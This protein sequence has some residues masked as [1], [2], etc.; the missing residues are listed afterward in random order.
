MVGEEAAEPTALRRILEALKRIETQLPSSMRN[1]THGASC[2]EWCK[3]W[4]FLTGAWYSFGWAAHGL[5]G[6]ALKQDL[7][8]AH[9][10]ADSFDISWPS[11]LRPTDINPWYTGYFLVAAEHRIANTMHRSCKLFLGSAFYDEYIDT[12]C[13]SIL[14]ECPRCKC[15]ALGAAA[16]DVV[17]A[18]LQRKT[19]PQLTPLGVIFDRVNIL[20]HGPVSDPIEDL[21]TKDRWHQTSMALESLLIMFADLSFHWAS[22]VREGHK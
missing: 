8:S 5:G 9:R 7:P 17:K 20:K 22:D 1:A 21:S 10:F 12:C 14:K 13:S 4:M 15:A 16:V 6:A 19:A 11:Q 2:D 18:F 3:L